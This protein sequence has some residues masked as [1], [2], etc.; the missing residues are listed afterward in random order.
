MF[1]SNPE[2]WII[3]KNLNIQLE[4]AQAVNTPAETDKHETVSPVSCFIEV[5]IT[6]CK[7][8][9]IHFPIVNKDV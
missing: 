8:L 2:Y 5:L 3:L 1:Q 4:C 9:V 6:R 7:G